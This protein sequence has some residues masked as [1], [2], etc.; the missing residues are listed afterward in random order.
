MLDLVRNPEDWLSC[1]EAHI[2]FYVSSRLST[3]SSK[4]IGV[5]IGN[6]LRNI[7]GFSSF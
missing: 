4:N 2:L 7:G 3:K 6:F 5:Y 1:V